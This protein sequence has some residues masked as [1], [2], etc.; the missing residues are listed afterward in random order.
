MSRRLYWKLCLSFGLAGVLLVTLVG[1]AGDWV[2]RQMSLLD[3]ADQLEMRQWADKAEG[4]SREGDSQALEQ[5]LQALQRQENTLIT[6]VRVEEAWLTPGLETPFT[7]NRIGRGLDWPMHLHHD[8]P[9]IQVPFTDGVTSLAVRLPAR[10]LPGRWWPYTHRLLQ[11]VPPVL[12][13][14]LLCALFYRH[15]M[16]PLRQLQ[17]ATRRFDAGDYDVRVYNS[18]G[19]RMDELDELA[20]TFDRMADHIGGLIRTQRHLIHDLS[21]ELRTPLTRLELALDDDMAAGCLR[22]RGRKEAQAMRQLVEDTLLLAALE[23]EPQLL[24]TQRVDLS[25]LLEVIVDDAR[26][27]YPDRQLRLQL[28]DGLDQVLANERALSQALENIIRNA[29]RHTPAGLAVTVSAKPL[30]EGYQVHVRDQGPGVPESELANI[31]LPFFRLDRS[32]NRDGGGAG[33]GLALARRQ[34]LGLGGCLSA[35]NHR[36]GGLVMQLWLPGS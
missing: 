15:L 12:L 25:L 9:I 23:H 31:F 34:I 30:D 18:T 1:M 21:H 29:L 14:L 26:Y 20:Q 13:M 16:R 8:T 3:P 35:V 6:V 7:L 11:V 2:E 10:M 32:R 33:L 36:E 4:F 19:R 27:E 5:W 22:E 28:A 17:Q 24:A